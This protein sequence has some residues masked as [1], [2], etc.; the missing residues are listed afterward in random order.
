MGGGGGGGALQRSP[1]AD[2]VFF[3][4]KGYI[5]AAWWETRRAGGLRESVDCIRRRNPPRLIQMLFAFVQLDLQ[6]RL[7]Q[8]M[9]WKIK[10]CEYA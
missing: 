9:L 1:D 10:Q 2:G 3:K 4:D 6:T 5:F 8:V 7:Q